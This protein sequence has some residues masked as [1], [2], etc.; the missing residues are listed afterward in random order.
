MPEHPVKAFIAEVERR[1]DAI[2]SALSDDRLAYKRFD[3]MPDGKLV[4]SL[5]GR[6]ANVAAIHGDCIDAASLMPFVADLRDVAPDRAQAA[7]GAV[8]LA[9]AN[10]AMVATTTT[11][12]A[13]VDPAWNAASAE[14]NSAKVDLLSF[15]LDKAEIP[16]KPP[17]APFSID[18]STS[19]AII[20]NGGASIQL[21]ERA[22]RWLKVLCDHPGKFISTTDLESHD[23]ELIGART[24]R[25]FAKLPRQLKKFIDPQPGKGSRILMA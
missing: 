11:P 7:I 6:S 19:T 9:I 15:R 22:A 10:C 23:T 14:L 4:E 24:D 1:F 21:D 25:L 18:L 2:Y 17:V 8:R 16:P 20:A 3:E 12:Y 13:P 5:A